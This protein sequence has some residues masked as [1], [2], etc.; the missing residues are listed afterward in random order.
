M[1]TK[2]IRVKM[3]NFLKNN[4]PTH[5]ENFIAYARNSSA[6]VLKEESFK[7]NGH[8]FKINIL[9]QILRC[10]KFDFEFL[11]RIIRSSI[12]KNS[13]L[14]RCAKFHPTSAKMK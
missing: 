8:A 14:N 13:S 5:F 4:P 11:L 9:A 10:V 3:R 7:K 1:C 6:F 2:R 12:S